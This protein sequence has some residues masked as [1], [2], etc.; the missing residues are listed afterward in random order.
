MNADCTTCHA[1]KVI[2]SGGMTDLDCI[3]CHMPLF[4]KSATAT[5]E[6]PMGDERP[7]LG[8]VRSHIFTIDMSK[9]PATEQFNPGGFAYPWLTV[10]RA[11]KTCHSPTGTAFDIDFPTAFQIH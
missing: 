10:E 2:T 5:F 4:S 7:A 1:D 9:D 8:D 6:P 3:D 11:C